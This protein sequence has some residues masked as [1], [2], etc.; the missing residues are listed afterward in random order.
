MK[1]RRSQGAETSRDGIGCEDG[2]REGGLHAAASAAPSQSASSR[3][4]RSRSR[5]STPVGR[6]RSGPRSPPTTGSSSSHPTSGG[7]S[8]S[9]R[10]TTPGS[11][12]SSKRRGTT[13]RSSAAPTHDVIPDV[14]AMPALREGMGP[15]SEPTP[16]GARLGWWC[17]E[18]TTPIMQTTYEAAR[19]SVD[20]A[21]S[22]AALVTGGE[23]F[24]YGLCRPPGH[25][26]AR[27][28][29][30][31]YCFF[32]NAAIVAHDLARSTGSKVTV[33]DVDYHHGNG[34]Q[35]IF[36]AAR[37]RP[38]RLAARRSGSCLSVRDGSRRRDRR[39]T[40]GAA[41]RRTSRSRPR[42]TTTTT[43]SRS[44]RRA[45]T[46][47]SSGRR[48]SSCRSGSTRTTSIR[49]AIS[50]SRPTA[51]SRAGRWSP[52]SGCRPWCCR[53][54]GTPTTISART[55]GGGCSVPRPG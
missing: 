6:R 54:A 38:V 40:R 3:A 32:N 13:T 33:L 28:A 39:R 14:F 11:W 5:S 17:F 18:T 7:R 44:P 4:R 31:G 16:I 2:R 37:R 19:S 51:S 45:R 43:S 26:A 27:A 21:L 48:C 23:R 12:R 36:Y 41:R 49:S 29:Y 22:A 35:Q 46:S 50:R 53:R 52:R 15:A 9:R 55:S 42:R 34:T 8:R 25:H 24:A 1:F 20:V 47:S 30:G 10:C